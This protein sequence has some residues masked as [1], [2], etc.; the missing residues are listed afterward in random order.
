MQIQEK[1]GKREWDVTIL[2]TC[3]RDR[4]IM[5]MESRVLL[6][7]F[8]ERYSN[9]HYRQR[10]SFVFL[11]TEEMIEDGNNRL[12]L[13][14]ILCFV[15]IW[16]KTCLYIQAELNR[17]PNPAEFYKTLL[18]ETLISCHIYL[19]YWKWVWVVVVQY[20]TNFDGLKEFRKMINL[21]NY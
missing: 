3:T 13:R 16:D 11:H 1:K 20:F 2:I 4:K 10:R 5:I 9:C 7:R 15:G 18:T 6:S 8:T 17:E 19:M 21:V 12:I 14:I